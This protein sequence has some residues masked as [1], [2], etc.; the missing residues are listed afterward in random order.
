MRA[1]KRTNKKQQRRRKIPLHRILFEQW[2]DIHFHPILNSKKNE[3]EKK[4]YEKRF[5]TGLMNAC[6]A[7]LI[8]ALVRSKTTNFPFSTAQTTNGSGIIHYVSRTTARVLKW[9]H[10]NKLKNFIVVFVFFC[11]ICLFKSEK[12]GWIKSRFYLLE[13]ATFVCWKWVNWN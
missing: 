7:Y 1:R 11:L 13:A 2:I 9:K 6:G 8:D 3:Q 10:R 5:D 12:P 4:K